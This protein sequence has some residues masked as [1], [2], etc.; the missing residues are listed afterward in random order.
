H[1][2]VLGY[3]QPLG[4]AADSWP[5]AFDSPVKESHGR[6]TRLCANAY[7]NLGIALKKQGDPQAAIA[8]HRKAIALQPDYA[9]A[10]NNLGVLLQEEGLLEQAVAAH[11]QAIGFRPDFAIA[12]SNLGVAFKEQGKIEQA[13]AAHRRAVAADPAH[14]K[15][16]FNF[17]VTLLMA[18]Q[19]DEGWR[20]YEWRWRGGVP[21]LKDRNFQQ[22]SW[23]GSDLS[24]RTLLLHAEQ[25]FG[26]TLQF[27]RFAAL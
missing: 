9:D 19:Y 25:G 24:G 15:V 7:T 26:D 2:A 20:E 12:H 23:D 16:H 27:V 13:I 8:A 3:R 4:L 11:R 14:P 5:I 1:A 10:H 18:G 21:A 6:S 22:P 17:G